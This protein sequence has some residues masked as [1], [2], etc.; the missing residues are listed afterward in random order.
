MSPDRCDVTRPW[1]S[2]R[3]VP[4]GCRMIARNWYRVLK[5]SIAN[6]FPEK[7]SSLRGSRT[8]ISERLIPI[9]RRKGCSTQVPFDRGRALGVLW[10][11]RV[12]RLHRE[13]RFR[14]DTKGFDS[15]TNT[16]GRAQ[17]NRYFITSLANTPPVGGYGVTESPR[18]GERSAV[19]SE[20]RLGLASRGGYRDRV[21]RSGPWVSRRRPM[22]PAILV[23]ASL[24]AGI[25]LIARSASA[26]GFIQ[27]LGSLDSFSHA[28][29]VNELGQ[30]V[31]ESTNDDF[32]N[33]RATL[34]ENGTMTDL[35][36]LGGG[37]AF[38]NDVNEAGQIVGASLD[39]SGYTRALQ[40]QNGGVTDI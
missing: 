14:S 39:A 17:T 35:G 24:I 7:S 37:T 6:T 20:C 15:R 33:P 3:G 1:R 32:R 34:W 31:G 9:G 5:A 13:F 8:T 30:I 40:G 38:A 28:R 21:P 23:I 29:A 4:F 10:L 36:S 11:S 12:T 26:D 19:A 18:E 22:L 2:M 27:D 16:N 25:P